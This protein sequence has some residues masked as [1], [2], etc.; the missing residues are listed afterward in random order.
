MR[1]TREE[2][3]ILSQKEPRRRE[4]C[5]NRCHKVFYYTEKTARTQR[6]GLSAT[7][8]TTLKAGKLFEARTLAE[9][10]EVET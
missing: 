1:L 9:E 2:E 3:A 6:E 5:D 4:R 8:A 7:L 10:D